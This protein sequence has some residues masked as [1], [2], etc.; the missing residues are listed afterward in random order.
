MQKKSLK[1]KNSESDRIRAHSRQ[2]PAELQ[3]H[4]LRV[5]KI[6]KKILVLIQLIG[7]N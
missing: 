4:M 2:I 5:R 3:S 7:H 1:K 6:L